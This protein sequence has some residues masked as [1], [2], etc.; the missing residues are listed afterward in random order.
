MKIS[1]GLVQEALGDA[2]FTAA[3]CARGRV[4]FG[5]QGRA[6]STAAVQLYGN[7]CSSGSSTACKSCFCSKVQQ[8]TNPPAPQAH[9][10]AIAW[11]CPEKASRLQARAGSCPSPSLSWGQ[12]CSCAPR[13]IRGAPTCWGSTGQSDAVPPHGARMPAPRVGQ[14]CPPQV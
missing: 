11:H 2:L 8:Q 10:T 6:L 5:A 13:P 3:C 4:C 7:P 1:P 9:G 12:F 14:L